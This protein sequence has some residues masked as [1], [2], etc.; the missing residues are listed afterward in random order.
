M[1]AGTLAPGTLALVRHGQTDWNLAGRMQGRTDIP[2]N[3]TGRR[4]AAAAAEALAA[5]GPWDLM[6]SSTLSRARETAAI[7]GDRL[8]LD[9]AGGFAGLDERAYGDAEGAVVAG[10]GE[11]AKRALMERGEPASEVVARGLGALSG[12]AA[13]HPGRRLVVVSHGTLIRLVLSALHGTGH[14]RVENGQHIL[15]AGELLAAGP[16]LSAGLSPR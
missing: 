13:A 16:R 7:I 9:Q 1:S 14:P 15:L 5:A 4:Q 8:G 10:L 2:L 6:A 12:L 11:D 3:A